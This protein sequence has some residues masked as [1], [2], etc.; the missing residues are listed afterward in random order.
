METLIKNDLPI[1]IVIVIAAIALVVF[2]IWRNQKDEKPFEHDV[3]E[4]FDNQKKRK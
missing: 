2:L 1:L 3:D 4:N